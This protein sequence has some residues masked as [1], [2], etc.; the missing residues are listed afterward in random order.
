MSTDKK[1]IYMKKLYVSIALLC[2]GVVLWSGCSDDKNP[3]PSKSHPDAWSQMSVS[4]NHGAKVLQSGLASCAECHGKDYTGDASKVSCY[5]CHADYPH[6]QDW[7]ASGKEG[8]HGA[9]LNK[10]SYNLSSCQPCHGSDFQGGTGKASCFK[11]HATYPHASDWM[12]KDK[13]KFHG[14]YLANAKY[15]LAECQLCHG[16]DYKG[17]DTKTSCY[18]C[19]NSFPH[20]SNWL[21]KGSSQFHGAF[22]QSKDWS[23]TSCQGCHG[24]DWQ[25]GPGKSPCTSCHSLYPHEAGWIQENNAKFHGTYLKSN[26]WSLTSCAGCHGPD[27]T[28]GSDKESCGR[29]HASYPHASGWSSPAGTTWHGQFIAQ[30]NWAMEQC[31]ECHG[32]DYKGGVSDKTCLSCHSSQG[33][34]ENCTLC[35]G[36]SANLAPPKALNRK[37]EVTEMGVGRHQL[38]VTTFKYNCVLCHVTPKSFS[39]PSHIDTTPN[40]EIVSTWKWDRNKGTCQTSCHANRP[41]LNYV[42]NHP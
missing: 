33:G 18:K 4:D 32:D 1:R 15:A 29:C 13:E 11:C 37:T 12:A 31:K 30:A 22:L 10:K 17:G 5:K 21:T 8:S 42:W 23:L 39:D 14:R 28:S 35:H 40:A 3:L 26:N 7:L 25:G 27:Y 34:P 38:H 36:S 24:T 41:E 16:A 9:Y 20:D 19:H 2:A 6:S